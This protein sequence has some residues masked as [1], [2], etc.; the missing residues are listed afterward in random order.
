MKTF[1]GYETEAPSLATAATSMAE[2]GGLKAAP[3][4]SVPAVADSQRLPVFIRV[5]RLEDWGKAVPVTIPQLSGVYEDLTVRI[6]LQL[7]ARTVLFVQI[8]APG[9]IPLN[10]SVPAAG[11]L[12]STKCTLRVQFAMGEI[13]VRVEFESVSANACARL[14]ELGD[15]ERARQLATQDIPKDTSALTKFGQ[16]FTQRLNDPT[17]TLLSRYIRLRVGDLDWSNNL[18]F[19]LADVF[20][21]MSDGAIISGELAARK[22]LHQQALTLLL[23]ASDLS[24]HAPPLFT[25][26]YK[27]LVSRLQQYSRP[28]GRLST[29]S[30]EDAAKAQAF[31]DKLDAYTPYLEVDPITVAFSGADLSNLEESQHPA[32]LTGDDWFRWP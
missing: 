22:G 9:L 23:R 32:D 28:T 15:Y 24:R 27:L 31:L 17:A 11:R 6:D 30:E 1:T 4:G 13:A 18:A 7:K 29:I 21:W 20:D 5:F 14:L 8:A 16:Q 26:G 10:V 19:S 3:L 25:E 2:I 12:I